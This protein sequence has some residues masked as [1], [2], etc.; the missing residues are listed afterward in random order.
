MSRVMRRT[1]ARHAG[2][3]LAGLVLAGLAISS[4]APARAGDLNAPVYGPYPQ[5]APDY[6]RTYERPGPCR[7][8]LE[9]GVDPYGRPIVHRLRVCDE[10]AVYSAPGV[11]PREYGYPRYDGPSRS[12]YYAYPR[13]PAPVGPGYY[14]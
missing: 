2:L 6:G 3:A 12:G 9:R 8:V 14:N 13:P 10:G 1:A 7:I 5:V 4:I 11:A